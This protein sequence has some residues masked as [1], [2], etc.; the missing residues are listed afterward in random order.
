[1]ADAESEEDLRAL[2][3]A[4]ESEG[5]LP[6]GSAGWLEP[7]GKRIAGSKGGQTRVPAAGAG[8]VI[9]VSGSPSPVSKRQIEHAGTSETI[10]VVRL[11]GASRGERERRRELARFTAEAASARAVGHDIVVDAAGEGRA[12]IRESLGD[13]ELEMRRESE[14]I[15][16]LLGEA[17]MAFFAQGP[18]GG[19]VVFGGETALNLCSRLGIAGLE[20]STEVEPFVP[21]GGVLGGDHEGLPV[22]TKAGGFGSDAVVEAAIRALRHDRFGT[23]PPRTAV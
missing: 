15:Q 7:V 17:V 22:V 8:P 23:A 19:L 12:A 21:L 1:V 2:A 13:D 16:S 10:D 6:C 5:A 11:Q 4:T 14:R 3:L 20:L 18:V 9:V